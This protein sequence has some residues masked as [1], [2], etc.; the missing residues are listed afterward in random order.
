MQGLFEFDRRPVGTSSGVTVQD[1][2]NPFTESLVLRH[3]RVQ[4]MTIVQVGQFSSNCLEYICVTADEI[5]KDRVRLSQRCQSR[6]RE[7]ER[8]LL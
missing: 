7:I 5:S 8:L 4:P 6:R 2:A 1:L 3:T